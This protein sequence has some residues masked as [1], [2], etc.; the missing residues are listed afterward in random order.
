MLPNPSI[1]P[2]IHPLCVTRGNYHEQKAQKKHEKAQKKHKKAQ[3]S[4]NT[5][6]LVSPMNSPM[7]RTMRHPARPA[8]SRP[9]GGIEALSAVQLDGQ[10]HDSVRIWIALQEVRESV[11]WS[12]HRARVQ[13]CPCT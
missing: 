6:H 12:V 8:K 11:P 9:F 4:T 13:V 2:S 1:H 7:Q 10:H 3:K 5:S